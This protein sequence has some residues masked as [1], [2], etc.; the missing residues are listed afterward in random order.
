M[1][2]LPEIVAKKT[3]LS[4]YDVDAILKV[5]LYEIVENIKEGRTV[6]IE[7]FG[8]F[9]PRISGKGLDLMIFVTDEIKKILNTNV[10]KERSDEIIFE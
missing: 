1:N 4:K 5:A 8:Y 2:T 6:K 7:N 10:K 9:A 3:G